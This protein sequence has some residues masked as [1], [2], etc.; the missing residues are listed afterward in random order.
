MREC[1]DKADAVG[2]D[3]V[4]AA[5]QPQ[6]PH[7]RVQ[8]L[9]HQIP[10]FQV[11]ASQGI[12]ER[13][14][15]D[16]GVAHNADG[17]DAEAVEALYLLGA[18]LLRQQ[19][20]QALLEDP[21]ELSLRLERLGLIVVLDFDAGVPR[22]R[23]LEGA[24]LLLEDAHGLPKS[25]LCPQSEPTSHVL[26][27][28][29]LDLQLGHRRLRTESENIQDDAVP[30]QHLHTW[31]NLAKDHSLLLSTLGSIGGQDGVVE[32]GVQVPGLRRC[33][34]RVDK[35]EVARVLRH[36]HGQLSY[37]PLA[38]IMQRVDSSHLDRAGLSV[39]PLD[40]R[41]FPGLFMHVELIVALAVAAVSVPTLR[42]GVEGPAFDASM[43]IA[44][45]GR[46][47]G[48]LV[49]PIRGI[50]RPGQDVP[51]HRAGETQALLGIQ[52]VRFPGFGS[53]A[54]QLHD[55]MDHDNDRLGPLQSEGQRVLVG[56]P[57]TGPGPFAERRGRREQ[58][59][60]ERG[61][62]RRPQRP[63]QHGLHT[64]AAPSMGDHPYWGG[65][66]VWVQ[67]LKRAA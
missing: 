46:L 37:L 15:P 12:H 4:P 52:E 11:G 62:Q 13:G 64:G 2:D 53:L 38:E 27:F 57:A 60:R 14:L 59:I 29:H 30:V 49:P 3:G 39:L 44:L 23:L 51:T 56:E 66:W 58:T 63:R 54:V 65:R 45:L 33:E 24:D 48:F 7:G 25:G 10:L 35:N 67:K 6:P 43:Q 5:G 41:A 28:R 40:H 18:V 34:R 20:F 21:Q 55:G 22:R 61:S 26:H 19:F 9:E 50:M 16:V 8:G 47:E 31:N 36:I 1:L 17:G 32:N 42:N